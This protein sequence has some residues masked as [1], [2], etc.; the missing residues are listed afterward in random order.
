MSSEEKKAMNEILDKE[1]KMDKMLDKILEKLDFF[2][3]IS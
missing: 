1:R 3:I 2:E